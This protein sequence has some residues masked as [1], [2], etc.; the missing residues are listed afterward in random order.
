MSTIEDIWAWMRPPLAD[1]KA[2][3]P[4]QAWAARR[5]SFLRDLGLQEASQHPV[6]EEL[7]RRLDE[8]PEQERTTMLGGDGIDSVIDEIAG[9]YA[10]SQDATPDEDPGQFA[11]DPA[12]EAA[13]AEESAADPGYDEQAWYAFLVESS[14]SWDGSEG[15]WAGY[16]QAFL[17]A[18]GQRG[19]GVPATALVEYLAT[20]GG[21]D[22]VAALAQYGVTVMLA[23]SPVSSPAAAEPGYD[24][25]AWYAFL[26]ES[27]PSWD[28]SESGW[29][30]YGQ[31]FLSAARQ[32]G[33]GV[34]AT[35]L[36][37]YLATLGGADRVAA[38]AQYGVLVTSA[39]EASALQVPAQV[40]A[41]DEFISSVLS[42]LLAEDPDLGEIP[43][44]R[45]RELAAEVLGQLQS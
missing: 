21:A 17:S 26:V 23:T 37:E 34:P 39:S 41:T 8:L 15:A 14:P 36:I 29:A 7:F 18:A 19:F 45:R 31:A 32:R 1:L 4:G 43:A 2:G 12:E 35:A 11:E 38:L 25:Q 22:R 30:G 3:E 9:Q 10:A 44:E 16:R 13:V 5:E 6:A 42:E 24:E 27:S 28:G 20:L 33:F 40:P